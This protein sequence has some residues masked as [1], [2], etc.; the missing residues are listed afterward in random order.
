MRRAALAAGDMPFP[1]LDALAARS[2]ASSSVGS[3]LA[4]LRVGGVFAATLL[5]AS[6]RLREASP[7]AAWVV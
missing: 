4:R 2:F 7:L 5:C 1:V 3:F 6:A